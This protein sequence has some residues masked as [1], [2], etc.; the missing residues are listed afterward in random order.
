[1]SEN[2]KAAAPQAQPP[3]PVEQFVIV[4]H[5]DGA[6]SFIVNSR[7]ELE[8]EFVALFNDPPDADDEETKHWLA[9][10]RNPDNWSCNY[11]DYLPLFYRADLEDGGVQVIR[12][13][14]L[15]KPAPGPAEQPAPPPADG[16]IFGH[17]PGCM[18]R[19]DPACICAQPSAP[20]QPA[21]Q[22]RPRKPGEGGK[23]LRSISVPVDMTSDDPDSDPD[24]DASP[25][26]YNREEHIKILQSEMHE[27]LSGCEDIFNLLFDQQISVGKAIEAISERSIGLAPSLPR[28][29]EPSVDREPPFSPEAITLMGE[30]AVM[31]RCKPD[32]SGKELCRLIEPKLAAAKREGLEAV[33]NL[34]ELAPLIM[35][36]LTTYQHISETEPAGMYTSGSVNEC[37]EALA[38]IAKGQ[39]NG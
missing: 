9:E 3:R 7:E 38:A 39:T 27:A 16:K 23:H 15:S 13:R 20:P 4:T 28:A 30:I 1:M 33:E 6:E 24:E 14:R 11:P 12:L 19:S 17:S 2:E 34:R 5:G 18:V 32:P 22:L 35:E 31:L 26:R 37:V 10:L 8:R 29:A 21:Q 25:T 36:M